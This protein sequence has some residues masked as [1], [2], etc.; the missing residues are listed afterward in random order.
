[1]Y[2]S[3]FLSGRC[4]PSI[5]YARQEHGHISSNYVN[6]CL[7]MSVVFAFFRNFGFAEVLGT[8]K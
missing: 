7:Q 4:E 3:V 1:M 5:V 8:R 2:G 6:F